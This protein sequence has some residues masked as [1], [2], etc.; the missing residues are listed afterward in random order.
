MY[1]REEDLYF[2]ECEIVPDEGEA[3]RAPMEGFDPQWI[4]YDP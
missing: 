1:D 3:P 4:G 2:M